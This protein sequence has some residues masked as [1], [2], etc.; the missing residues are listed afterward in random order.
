M[1]VYLKNVL[2]FYKR[3]ISLSHSIATEHTQAAEDCPMSE[4]SGFTSASPSMAA[5]APLHP[6]SLWRS[7]NSSTCPLHD[8]NT[9]YVLKVWMPTPSK[10]TDTQPNLTKAFKKKKITFSMEAPLFLPEVFPPA[11]YTD[12]SIFN[13]R[14]ITENLQRFKPPPIN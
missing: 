8:I 10:L 12:T 13:F 7:F 2:L 1:T 14:L 9:Y 3:R 5:L 4:L 6:S 11:L